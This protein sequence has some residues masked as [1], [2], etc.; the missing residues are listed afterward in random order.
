[1][2]GW[3]VCLSFRTVTALAL[4][5]AY[6]SLRSLPHLSFQMGS[7]FRGLT[8]RQSHSWLVIPLL[9]VPAFLES[10]SISDHNK[11]FLRFVNSIL[12]LFVTLFEWGKGLEEFIMRVGQL[13][14]NPRK[15]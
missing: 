12:Q 14:P 11:T 8:A 7:L 2:G 3:K 5:P 13:Q 9:L 10:R 4:H 1:M 6:L 15:L